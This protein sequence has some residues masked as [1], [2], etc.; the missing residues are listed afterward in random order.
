M[1]KKKLNKYLICLYSLILLG[2]L[3]VGGVKLGLFE[4]KGT[5]VSI[6]YYYVQKGTESILTD[7]PPFSMHSSQNPEKV[8]GGIISETPFYEIQP[9]TQNTVEIITS[10]PP[11]N[12]NNQEWLDEINSQLLDVK[13]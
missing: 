3:L 12:F 9:K 6:D 4:N 7:S 11:T 10:P 1:K 2:L 13:E 8:G 5:L